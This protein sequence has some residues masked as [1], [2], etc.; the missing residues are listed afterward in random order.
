M[1]VVQ[2]ADLETCLTE[3]TLEPQPSLCAQ[4][5]SGKLSSGAGSS[6]CNTPAL[7]LSLRYRLCEPVW[8]ED[9]VSE[10]G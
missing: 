8:D 2:A 1:A 10:Q 3:L 7:T 9:V 6:R 5:A 4:F